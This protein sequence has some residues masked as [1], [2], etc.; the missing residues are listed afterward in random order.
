MQKGLEEKQVV[1]FIYGNIIRKGQY[2]GKFK[3]QVN[4]QGLKMKGG[5]KERKGEREKERNGEGK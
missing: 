1:T 3:E 5:D 4:K 2:I